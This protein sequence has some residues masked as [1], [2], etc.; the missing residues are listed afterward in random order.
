MKAKIKDNQEKV[1]LNKQ[2]P[3]LVSNVVELLDTD[4]NDEPEEDGANIDLDAHRKGTCAVIKT[5]TRQV[6]A[7]LR[8]REN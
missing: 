7:I 2:L 3:Y 1:K 5:S 6:G 8:M 4:P